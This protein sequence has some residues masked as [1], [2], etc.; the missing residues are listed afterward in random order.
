MAMQWYF[1]TSA[2]E[3]EALKKAEESI[4][5]GVLTEL[6]NKSCRLAICDYKN[7]VC[8]EGSRRRV[9]A[10]HTQ[11]I[12]IQKRHPSQTGTI[13]VNNKYTVYHLIIVSYL[14]S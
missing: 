14:N 8:L 4:K 10:I 6:K 3:A 1:S 13:T 7:S 12:F 11:R 5:A 2:R 9:H